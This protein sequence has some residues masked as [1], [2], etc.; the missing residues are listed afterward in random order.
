MTGITGGTFAINKIGVATDGTIYVANMTINATTSALKIYQWANE[1]AAP[2]VV[3][4]G[5]P[6]AGS[7]LGDSMD[8]IGSGANTRIALGYSNSPTVAGN[9]GYAILENSTG[10]F[11]GNHLGFAGVTPA[12]GDHR[13]GITFIGQNSILGGQN[14]T[15]RRSSFTLPGS[16]TF[17]NSPN[18]GP[19]VNNQRAYDY[20]EINGVPVLITLDSGGVGATRDGLGN[21]N[22]NMAV[23]AWN[24]TDWNAPTLLAINVIPTTGVANANGTGE[25]KF[26]AISG[27]TA[28]IYAMATNNGIQSFNIEVVPEPASMMAI[29][30][31]LLAMMNR[32]RRKA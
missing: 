24:V 7:R 28:T 11:L 31:G 5:A 27:S 30:A 6:L 17:L 20:A 21:P 14:S 22:G 2:T 18:I 26:G 19:G 3:Y 12:A 8:V 23:R 25:I 9:N 1:A 10:T 29:G 13:L 16:A 4:S 32:K 15:V